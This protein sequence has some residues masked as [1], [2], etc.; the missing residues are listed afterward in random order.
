VDEEEE[1]EADDEDGDY[2]VEFLIDLLD[3]SALAGCSCVVGGD[4]YV[5]A[6]V[7]PFLRMDS[8]SSST[9]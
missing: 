7:P 6:G 5:N 9:L 1:E 2:L 3:E 8:P 4:P